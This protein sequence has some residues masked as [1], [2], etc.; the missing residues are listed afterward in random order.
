MSYFAAKMHQIR[1]R[2]GLCPRPRWGRKLSRARVL[3]LD[4]GSGHTAY[5]RASLID[6]YLYTKF[7]WNWR[8]FLWTDG[9]TYGR[10]FFPL[11][12]I[13]RSTFG[14]RPKNAHRRKHCALAV[15]RRRQKFPPQTLFPGAR[16]GQNLISWRWSLPSTTDPVSWRSMHAIS[17]YRGN[18]PTN[19]QTH[20]QTGLITIHCAAKLSAQC[21][22]PNLKGMQTN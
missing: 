1:F 7:H 10:T 4:L 22:Q 15:V 5:R 16:D 8:K 13:I 18:R 9:R 19:K 6:L 17:S 12:N 20:K 11:S 14:S 21:N 2:L 3:D